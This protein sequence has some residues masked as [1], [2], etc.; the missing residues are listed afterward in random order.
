VQNVVTRRDTSG[1]GNII[2][3]GEFVN[4]EVVGFPSVEIVAIFKGKYGDIA[5]V[6]RTEVANAMPGVVRGF[7]VVHPDISDADLSSTRV[8]VSAARQ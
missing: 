6:S 7:A 2:A 5:G 3:E 8:I 4:D 1:G